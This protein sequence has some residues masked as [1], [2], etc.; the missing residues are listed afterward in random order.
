MSMQRISHYQ[1]RTVGSQHHTLLPH[2]TYGMCLPAQRYGDQHSTP[3]K[4]RRLLTLWSLTSLWSLFICIGCARAYTPPPLT[5]QHPAHPEAMAAP[6][7]PPSSTLAYRAAESPAPPPAVTMAQARAGQAAV[8]GEG[9]IIA[10][11]PSSQQVVVDHKAIAGFMDAMTMGY[12]VA[13]LSLL[14][15]LQPGDAV[16]FTIDTEQNPIVKLE[17]LP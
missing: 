5:V 17:K 4:V 15:G 12:R 16:R 3:T 10:L 14:Q 2:G 8:V 13:S 6:V 9:K 1:E 11:V 7:P